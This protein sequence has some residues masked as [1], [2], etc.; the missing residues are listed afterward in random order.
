MKLKDEEQQ[1]LIWK[2]RILNAY[3]S[4]LGVVRWLQQNQI[5]PMTFYRWRHKLVTSGDISP[6][7]FPRSE[8]KR[9]N[10]IELWKKRIADA[11]N[12]GLSRRQW[13]EQQEVS[14]GSFQYW[15]SYFSDGSS[16]KARIWKERILEAYNSNLSITSW[17]K[18]HHIDIFQFFK[19]KRVLIRDGILPAEMVSWRI[20]NKK[21]W[22]RMVLD[23][24]SSKYSLKEWCRQHQINQR[25]LYEW[26]KRL[27]SSRDI[28]SN[29]LVKLCNRKEYWKQIIL[30]AY[31]SKIRIVD[32]CKQHQIEYCELLRWKN[33]LLK[34]GDLPPDVCRKKTPHHQDYW[35][36]IVLEAYNSDISIKDW[37]EQHDIELT[38]FSQWTKKLINRGEISV[39]MIAERKRYKAE[40]AKNN[41]REP[42][43]CELLIPENIDL[44][45]ENGAHIT[46]GT[47]F[48]VGKF[49]LSVQ[50][51]V[52]EDMFNSAL[53]ALNTIMEVF[54]ND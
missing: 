25:I 30:E 50:E 40:L 44:P 1:V 6:D 11:H 20:R 35:K 46:K 33:K 15:N 18:I 34:S 53:E 13:C 39:E 3:N 43:F 8:D 51:D 4:K 26:K 29:D 19:W 2:Q 47:T 52:S 36:P 54:V 14:I 27:I 16:K 10:N 32:W 9:K 21:Y 12:S 48:R 17:C 45:E 31:S 22:K 49:S 41:P 28:L 42:V 37:C 23:A 38:C 7:M 5:A 24:Y